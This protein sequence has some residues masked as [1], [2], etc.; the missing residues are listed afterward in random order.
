LEAR[1][2]R[3]GTCKMRQWRQNVKLHELISDFLDRMRQER[4]YS[5]NTIRAYEADLRQFFDFLL[6]TGRIHDHEADWKS[7]LVDPLTVRSYLAELFKTH[8]RSTIARKL[9]SLRSFFTFLEKLGLVQGNPAAEV[10]TPR[11]R[12]YIP[13]HLTVDQA[14]RLLDAPQRDTM[15]GL[16]DAAVLE[17]L[18]SCGLRVSELSN[19]DVDS[20]DLEARI[21]RVIG[22]GDKERL[23]PVGRQAAEVLG[24]YLEASRSKRSKGGRGSRTRALFIN[25][26]GGRLTPRSISRIIKRYAL[27]CGLSAEISPHAMRHTFATHMLDGGADLRAVQELLGH[28]SLSTTQKYT[29]LSLDRLMEVYDKAHPRSE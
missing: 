14:F 7:D 13:I 22:K 28:E 15:L 17:M 16:R 10:S 26:R 18:Y 24:R 11:L 2:K 12:K 1:D 27:E 23:V 21:V 25:Y 20:V 19:L 3:R 8:Q 4:G 9:S 5:T 6:S 29:H